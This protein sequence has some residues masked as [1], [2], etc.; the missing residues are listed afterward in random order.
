MAS[1]AVF[2]V[3]ITVWVISTHPRLDPWVNKYQLLLGLVFFSGMVV[4]VTSHYALGWG[5]NA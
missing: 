5:R 4:L 2:V 3:C 1:V